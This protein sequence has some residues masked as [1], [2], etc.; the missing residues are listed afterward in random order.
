VATAEDVRKWELNFGVKLP[1]S[2]SRVL[3]LQNGGRLKGTEIDIYPLG[4]FSNLNR[5]PWTEMLLPELKEKESREQM[6]CV[7]VM[8]AASVI[9]DYRQSDEPRVRRM[10]G[11][12]DGEMRGEYASFD[13]LVRS[14]QKQTVSI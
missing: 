3:T 11:V 12:L 9:L 7:G 1:L 8:L 14:I 2:L 13:A 10:D 5:S 4:L 6:I